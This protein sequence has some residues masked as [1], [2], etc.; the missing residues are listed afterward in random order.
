MSLWIKGN[1]LSTEQREFIAAIKKDTTQVH[2]V[3]GAAGTG[4]TTVLATLAQELRVEQPDASFCYLTYTH[5]LKEL[6][7]TS[8]K[9]ENIQ[10][11]HFLT[12]SKFLSNNMRCDFVLLDEVQ[13]I[14]PA[15]LLKIKNL[16]KHLIIA[17]DCAQSIYE[18]SSSE[19][20]IQTGLSAT[21]HKL[22]LMHR[23]TERLAAIANK[24][25]PSANIL[26]SKPSNTAANTTARLIS[27]PDE[28]KE[29]IWVAKE[30]L[31][32]ARP[33]KPSCILFS[34]HADITK[35]INVLVT[36]YKTSD[37]D[38][39]FGFQQNRREKYDYSSV[40]KHLEH[41]DMNLRYL[42]NGCGDLKEIDQ[43]PMVYIMTYHSAKGLDFDN[44]FIPQ[45]NEKKQ[46]ALNFVLEKNP[47]LDKRLLFVA[48]TRSRCNLFLTYSS[49]QPHPLISDLP[50]LTAVPY[51]PS[52]EDDDEDFF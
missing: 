7:E 18:E 23:L 1:K 10:G 3:Q 19:E 14:K 46:I 34:H 20:Q 44:V 2:W 24:I 32:R 36:E 22:I 28:N 17:G 11:V 40:N 5:A 9:D 35:F 27:H 12:H 49:K 15:D 45:L 39:Q 13:D 26:G 52:H 4:K 8:F 48:I 50:D 42:G 37:L 16:A 43:K 51:Q 29:L 33:A 38:P 47:D 31:S 41:H 21:Q 25:L 30:A 6:A